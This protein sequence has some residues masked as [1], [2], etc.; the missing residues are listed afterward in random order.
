MHWN[1]RLRIRLLTLQSDDRAEESEQPRAPADVP[2]RDR[3]KNIHDTPEFI[4]HGRSRREEETRGGAEERV[5]TPLGLGMGAPHRYRGNHTASRTNGRWQL[6]FSAHDG[7]DDSSLAKIL[8]SLVRTTVFGQLS[9]KILGFYPPGPSAP[10]T[11]GLFFWAGA[12]VFWAA[13]LGS[14]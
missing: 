14:D 3:G 9:S 7:A 4:F 11:F 1:K 13:F 5:A 12:S 2:F 6:Q 8:R 10:T